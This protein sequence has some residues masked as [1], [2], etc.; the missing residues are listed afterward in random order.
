MIK[1]DVL[2]IGAGAAG[3]MCALTAGSKGRK[4]VLIEH[5][6]KPG[7][8]ILIS[9]GGRCNFTNIYAAHDNFLSDNPDFCRSA[10]ARYTPQDFIQMVTNHGITFHEKKLGQLFCDGSAKQIVEMLLKE[11]RE[12]DVK[13]NCGEKVISVSKP[14]RFEITTSN[15]Q[16]SATSLIIA[17]GGISIP[18]MGA[19]GFG[20]DIARQFGLGLTDIKPGLVPFILPDKTRNLLSKIS[21]VSADTIVSLNNIAFRE[22]TLITHKG[23]SGPAILQ[24]SSYWN[25]G[26]EISVNF[27][28]DNNLVTLIEDSRMRKTILGNF[29]SVLL[30][31]SLISVIVPDNVLTKSMN[32]ISNAEIKSLYSLLCEHTFHPIGTEGFDKAEVTCGGVDTRELSSKTMEAVKVKGLYFIGEVVDVTGWLGGYNFQ[33][34]WA[35]GVA[36]GKSC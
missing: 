28:P 26:D 20:Y 36:A 16:Y 21:G 8:K 6:E 13:I 15:D 14:D 24:A 34:A 17:T 30:P 9:G 32:Q 25:E 27:L 35:S 2:I 18:K 4:V 19:T 1:I 29:T 11:C 31:Q 23:L 5:T 3:L 7:K 22:S 12:S 10:L 33:W